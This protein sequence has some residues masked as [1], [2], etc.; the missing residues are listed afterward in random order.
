MLQA[1]SYYSV[2]LS[3]HFDIYE[4]R[5]LL[6][7]VQ[8]ARLLMKKQ[9]RYSDFMDR[10]YCVDG[11]NVVFAVPL[12]ELVGRKS[13]NYDCIKA[14]ARRMQK[15]WQ[16]EYYD[17]QQK[18]WFLTS[19]I[20]NVQLDERNG[21]LIFSAAQWLVKYICDFRNGGYREYDFETAMSM[22]SPY[23][24]RMY[25]LT[26]SQTVAR[27]FSIASL[28]RIMGVAERYPRDADFIRRCIAPAAKEL[29]ERNANG[30]SFEVIR[31]YRD[32]PRS[33]PVAL[34]IT[35]VKRAARDKNIGDKISIIKE[36]VPEVITQYL[37]TQWSFSW[38][39]IAANQKTLTEFAKLPNFQAL[40]FSIS[41]RA[42]RK[43]KGHGYIINAMKSTI[44]ESVK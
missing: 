33:K 22:R 29:E 3:G 12:S 26:C 23:S 14:A 41:E 16:V 13:H 28:K 6:K 36:S 9:G 15:E 18:K 40:F 38:K 25:L 32:K 43:Y 19:V 27:K 24:A 17:K 37:V 30:F 8:R 44:R 35:P 1:Q 21:V 7:I 20:Y 42:R 11:Y 4:M 39:E 2:L 31:Q 10:A 34:M 5:I